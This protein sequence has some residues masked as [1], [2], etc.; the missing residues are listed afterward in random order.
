M[1][2][3]PPSFVVRL[4]GGFAVVIGGEPVPARAW[5]SRKAQALVKLLALAPGQRLAR[6]EIIEALW[7]ESDA[8]TGERN[9]HQALYSARRALDPRREGLLSLRRQVLSLRPHDPPVIDLVAFQEAADDARRSRTVTAY[10]E[11]LARYTG[12]LLPDDRYEDWASAPREAARELRFALLGE[13]AALHEAA[14]A[15]N[16][17]ILATEAIVAEEATREEAHV[18]LMRLHALAGRRQRALAQFGQLRAALR[19][20]L[21]AEPDTESQRLYGAILAGRFPATPGEIGRQGASRVPHNLPAPATRLIGREREVA[22]ARALLEEARLVTLVGAGGCGKTRL[23]LAMGEGLL[24][25]YPDGIWFI[26]LAP[27]ADGTLVAGAM[28]QAVGVREQPDEP[29]LDTLATTLRSRTAL[30]VLDNCEHII[31]VAAALAAT[32]LARCPDLAIIATSR[33]A[34]HT[35]GELVWRVPSL[36]LPTGDGVTAARENPAAQLFAERARFAQPGFALTAENAAAVAAICR[37][38]DGIPLALELAAAR[39][40]HLSLAQIAARLDDA[41][42]LLTAGG[43]TAPPRQRT[44]AATLDWS[45]ALLAAAERR[46][47]EEIAVFAGGFTLAAAEA[48]DGGPW[49]ADGGQQQ[50]PSAVHSPPPADTLDTLAALVDKSLVQV[51]PGAEEPRYRLLETVRQYAL[52]RLAARGDEAAARDRH[53]RYFLDL[54][55]EAER[56][57]AGPRQ[58]RRLAELEREIDNLRGALDWYAAR[59]GVAGLRLASTLTRF[60][61]SGTHLREGLTRLVA[62]LAQASESAAPDDRAR[63]YL[64]AAQLAMSCGDERAAGFA[65]AGLDLY[66]TV[67]D[68]DKQAECCNI[69]GTTAR[70]RGDYEQSRAYFLAARD[71]WH[72]AGNV[73][74]EFVA[75][76]NLASEYFDRGEY[77]T[78]A[79]MLAAAVPLARTHGDPRLLS[80]CLGNLGLGYVCTGQLDRA[81]AVLREAIGLMAAGQYPI[82]LRLALI[83]VALLASERGEASATAQF[84]GASARVGEVANLAPIAV[85]QRFADR[86]ATTA[87]AIVDETAFEAAYATGKAWPIEQAVARAL[88]YLAG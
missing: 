50:S 41:L 24:A 82:Y 44:L 87:R 67:G 10:R 18:A 38:L 6:D 71:L 7:P 5:E 37:R 78:A 1:S 51:E 27:L 3:S 14:S 58:A 88:A 19:R 40:G 64:A 2:P 85:Q 74:G 47:L 49:T 86:A 70:Y 55:A 69:L 72:V 68:R 65:T 34:L 42:R 77:A 25:R 57:L 29:L 60:W 11:A 48:M 31:E 61:M 15:W 73:R 32:L 4:L 76:H 13:L 8:A 23:A 21:D 17:A 45:Y 43:R 75:A 59:D 20:D 66:R 54:A 62:G 53:A 28:A 56:E 9:F 46:L 84:L 22:Q 36:P 83:S 26:D 81:P 52:A 63:A 33:E 12:E 16:D 80:I 30:L 35:S 79:A 39:V